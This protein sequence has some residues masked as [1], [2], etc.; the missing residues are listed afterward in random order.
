M[1]KLTQE[2][3]KNLQV[4]LGRVQLQGSEV[5]VFNDLVAALFAEEPKE[6]PKK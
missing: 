6:E 2:Q 3:K 4:F 1:I 5:A